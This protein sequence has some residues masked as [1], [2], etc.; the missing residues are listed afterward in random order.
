MSKRIQILSPLLANQIAAG[1]VV[2]RPA[3]AV[4]ELVENSLDA[5]ATQVDIELEQGGIRLIRVRD[6]G[7][8]IYQDDLPLAMS[9]HATSKINQTEDLANINTLGFR[10][11]AL[12]SIGSVS[13]L[14]ITSAVAGAAGSRVSV[15][16]D[17]ASAIEPAAHP[18]GTT[19]EV[20]DLFFN[21]PARR[22]FLRTEKTEFDHI[23]ELIKRMALS[24]FNVTFTLR[25]NQRMLRQYHAVT[26]SAHATE[27]LGA[28]C[29]PAFV[30][31]AVHVEAEGAGMTLSGWI[32][33]PTFSRSQGDQQYFY[34]NGRMIRDK[35]ILH[36]LKTAYQDMLYRDRY[37]VYV[38]FLTVPPT[39][40]DV[41]VHPTKHEVR[42]REGRT[43]HDFIFRSIH[44]ALANVR[45]GDDCG[46]DH[47]IHEH[48]SEAKMEEHVDQ[49]TGEIRQ[50]PVRSMP[51][52]TPSPSFAASKPRADYSPS[53][54]FSQRSSAAVPRVQ[55]QL[56]VYR[57]L[58]EPLDNETIVE[59]AVVSSPPLGNA[60]GQVKDIYILAENEKGLVMID[61]HAAHERVMYEKMK[62]DMANHSLAIQQLLVPVTVALSEREVDCA[63]QNQEF[64]LTLGFDVERI[65]KET[66]A[67]RAVPQLLMKGPTEQLIRDIV[68]DL[69][70]HGKS[71]RAQESVNRLLGTLACHSAVRANRRLTIPEMNALLRDMEKTDHSG[72]CNHGR[73]TTVQLS[74]D[75]LDKLFMRGR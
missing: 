8:G 7:S 56:A 24:S 22:K 30:E 3:A 49:E 26:S 55:E 47:A 13:R 11:E 33:L 27:R 53:R 17:I 68:A 6:N 61:M 44:D 58:H 41:N 45:P 36:A 59:S 25:H 57:T 18:Q 21:T 28:L 42:F 20:R 40:V 63:E 43:V 67:V 52:S 29:G 51:L 31:N 60:L 1:E 34:V 2:E 65:G 62:K 32:G 35:L 39:T 4:K 73:P 48:Q 5:G 72:Q 10:G 54:S 70:Q 19:V 69:L 38:L 37:P 66:I 12:A 71:T 75:D 16:G 15:E 23:D 9:R 50:F 14:T 64:F 46:H 74:L